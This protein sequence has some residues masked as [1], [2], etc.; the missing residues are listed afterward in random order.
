MALLVEQ[1]VSYLQ[2]SKVLK[3]LNIKELID[4]FVF[5]VYSGDN[6]D[7]GQKSIALCLIFQDFS[8]TLEEQEIGGHIGKIMEALEKET[9]AVL[10]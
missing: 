6:I 3:K 10:R 7:L 4:T 1:K 9:G 5:D 2:I 8:R